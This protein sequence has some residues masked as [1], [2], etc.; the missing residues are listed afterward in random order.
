VDPLP[1]YVPPPSQ[2]APEYDLVLQ[3]GQREKTY[4]HSRFREQAWARKVSPD[5]LVHVHPDTAAD[6]GVRDGDWAVVEAAGGRGGCRLKVHVSDRTQ[7]GVL[8]TG[9]GWWRPE[10]PGPEFGVLE[11]N[12]NAALSY[13]GAMDPATGSVDTG[14]IRCR[15]R[16]A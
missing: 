14:A 3:T 15:M 1:D 9:I 5:P 4:H 11:V 12:I 10:A 7:P 6:Q 8:T 16:A 13:Q 2:A